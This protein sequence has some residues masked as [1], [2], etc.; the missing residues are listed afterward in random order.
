[1]ALNLEKGLEVKKIV[2][3]HREGNRKNK[4]LGLICSC[5][6]RDFVGDLLFGPLG[7]I[8]DDGDGS[9]L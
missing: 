9:E 2:M 7:V 5:Q 6:S 3:E 1:V 8:G 4:G